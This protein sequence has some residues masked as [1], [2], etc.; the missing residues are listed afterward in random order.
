MQLKNIK[1]PASEMKAAQLDLDAS[2]ANQALNQSQTKLDAAQTKLDAKSAE[3]AQAR[4]AARA[5]HNDVAESRTAADANQASIDDAQAKLAQNEAEITAARE[6][7]DRLSA[8]GNKPTADE[9][10]TIEANQ[11]KI[12]SLEA[13]NVDIKSNIDELNG[14]K[15]RIAER[16]PALERN[17]A[18]KVS[19]LSKLE[20]EET[21]LRGDV[22]KLQTEV[23]ANAVEAKRANDAH[24]AKLEKDAGTKTKEIAELEQKVEAAPAGSDERAKLESNLSDSRKQLD[25]I[26]G[27]LDQARGRDFSNPTSP[28]ALARA[29]APET[30]AGIASSLEASNSRHGEAQTK[31]NNAITEGQLKAQRTQGASEVAR[32]AG[33]MIKSGLETIAAGDQAEGQELTALSQTHQAKQEEDSEFAK[34]ADEL[35]RSVQ[36][37]LKAVLE[38]FERTLSTIYRNM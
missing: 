3:V 33:E 31:F 34:Q 21:A 14:Q 38:A 12:S 18:A 10:D 30:R 5:A 7:N 11:R 25:G 16:H 24:I 22:A 19:D 35:I 15:A 4:D 32:G 8:P 37:I 26:N 20:A 17:E 27:R 1:G 2:K 9:V 28:E 36:D 13:E 23:E 29:K 6:E